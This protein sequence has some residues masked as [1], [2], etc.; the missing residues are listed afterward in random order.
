[1]TKRY[2]VLAF[3][4]AMVSFA[5]VA[6]ANDEDQKGRC[7]FSAYRPLKIGTPIQGGHEDLAVERHNPVYPR[8]ALSKRIAGR[9]VVHVLVNRAGDVVKACGVEDVPAVVEG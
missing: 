9:V 6:S 3:V 8:E 5:F 2:G 7:D 4:L 1:M